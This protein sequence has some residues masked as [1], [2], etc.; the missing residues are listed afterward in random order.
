MSDYSW[1]ASVNA[2]VMRLARHQSDRPRRR[3]HFRRRRLSLDELESRL[4]PVVSTNFSAGTLLLIVPATDGPNVSLNV[5]SV[6]SITSNA[7]TP[8]NTV[9]MTLVGDTFAAGTGTTVPFGGNPYFT[10]GTA[11]APN[12][13]LTFTTSPS[14]L[15]NSITPAVTLTELDL[16]LQCAGDTLSLNL[17]AG[18]AQSAEVKT[19]NINPTSGDSITLNAITISGALS[20][21][22]SS[23][24]VSP[25]SSSTGVTIGGSIN[26][27]GGVSIGGTSGPTGPI[28]ISPGSSITTTNKDISMFAKTLIVSN[29]ATLTPNGGSVSLSEGA[30]VSISIK[31]AQTAVTGLGVTGGAIS[32]SNSLS[33]GSF[34]L[35]GGNVTVSNALNATSGNISITGT[36]SSTSDGVDLLNANAKLTATGTGSITI[37]GTANGTGKGVVLSAATLSTTAGNIAIT[38]S[39]SVGVAMIGGSIGS[40]GGGVTIS[41]TG[42]GTGLSGGAYGVDI[43]PGSGARVSDASTGPVKITGT[44]GA[45]STT[46]TN[47]NAGVR[48]NGSTTSVTV[49]NGTLNISGTGGGTGSDNFGVDIEG[50]AHIMVATPTSPSTLADG[51]AISIT[52]PA[53]GGAGAT[54][55]PTGDS[56]DGVYISGS[57]TM[58][59]AQIGGVNISGTGTGTG[60]NE[61]GVDIDSGASATTTFNGPIKI[62]GTG[63]VVGSTGNTGVLVRGTVNT[64]GGA[65]GI[66]GTGGGTQK[67]NVGI[68]LETGS[69]VE[70]EIGAITLTGTG[71]NGSPDNSKGDDSDDSADGNVGVQIIGS[72]VTTGAGGI[73]I[74]GTGNGSGQSEIGVLIESGSQTVPGEEEPVTETVASVVTTNGNGSIAIKG[75]GSALGTDN[76]C[77]VDITSAQTEV[78]TENGALAIT[79]TGGGST[80]DNFGVII[81]SG[82]LVTNSNNGKGPIT[83]AGTGGDGLE[84]VGGETTPT[85]ADDNV[86]VDIYGGQVSAG[87]GGVTITGTGNGTGDDERG[88]VIRT[89][90][91]AGSAGVS[92]NQNGAVTIKGT[93]S[94][95]GGED[96]DGVFIQGVG[97]QLATGSGALS[98]SGIGGGAEYGNYG[99]NLQGMIGTGYF[100]PSVPAGAINLSGTGG[101]GNNDTDAGD[102]DLGKAEN[103]GVYIISGGQITGGAGGVVISGTA[104]GQGNEEYG[105]DLEGTSSVAVGQNGNLKITGTAS[106]I[107]FDY[108][109]GVYVNVTGTGPA[110]TTGSGALTITGTGG[111]TDSWNYGIDLNSG[112]I[113]SQQGGAVSLSGTAGNGGLFLTAGIS[114]GQCNEGVFISG[115]QVLAGGGGLTITGTGNGQGTLARGVD[116][117]GGAVIAATHN[118]DGP[119]TIKGTGGSIALGQNSGIY[120][121]GNGTQLTTGRGALSV[122]GA[123]GGT[124]VQNDGVDV[125]G[126]AVI[127]STGGGLVSVSGTC[128]PGTSNDVGV[129]VSGSSAVAP[130]AVTTTTGN[131]TITGT[132]GNGTGNGNVGVVI[133]AGGQVSTQRGTIT[134][135]GTGNGLGNNEDGVD[136]IGG[137]AVTAA[138]DGT[139]TIK[140]NGGPGSAS[141]VGV[142][143]SDLSGVS[144][145]KTTVSTAYGPLSITGT[146]GNGIGNG[147]DGVFMNSATIQ[148]NVSTLT[149]GVSI[150]GIGSGLGSFSDGVDIVGGVHLSATADGTIKISGTGSNGAPDQNDNV[151]VYISELSPIITGSQVPSGT[152]VSL[153]ASGGPQVTTV[154]GV[155]SLNGTGGDFP[156]TTGTVANGGSNNY[157]VAIEAN[158]LITANTVAPAPVGNFTIVGTGGGGL[159]TGNNNIGVYLI[160]GGVQLKGGPASTISGTQGLGSGANNQKVSAAGIQLTP[161]GLVAVAPLPT[162]VVQIT[163]PANNSSIPFSNG[164]VSVVATLTA[165]ITNGIGVATLDGTAPTFHYYQLMNGTVQKDLG[166]SAPTSFG[167]YQ[168]TPSF[169]GSL[170]YQPSTGSPIDFSIAQVAPTIVFTTLGSSPF[171]KNAGGTYTASAIYNGPNIGTTSPLPV[172]ALV[173]G[174]NSSPAASLETVTLVTAANPLVYYAGTFAS[175]PIP[176]GTVALPSAPAAVGNYTVVAKFLGSTDYASVSV[177]ANFSITQATPTIHITLPS[178]IA[179]SAQSPDV[180]FPAD[181]FITGAGSDS[182]NTSKSLEGLSLTL[183]YSL[184]NPDGSFTDLNSNSLGAHSTVAGTYA[185]TAHFAATKD[186]SAPPALTFVFNVVAGP[187]TAFVVKYPNGTTPVTAGTLFGLNVTP[188]DQFGNPTTLSQSVSVTSSDPQASQ[189]GTSLAITNGSVSGLSLKTANNLPGQAATTVTVTDPLDEVVSALKLSI[190]GTGYGSGTTV[191]FSGGGGSGAAATAVIANGVITALTITNPGS[192]YTT[193]PTVSFANTGGGTGAAAT[194]TVTAITGSTTVP[195]QAAAATQFVLSA[196]GGTTFNPPRSAPIAANSLTTQDGPL[197]MILE[198]VDPFGNVSTSYAKSVNVTDQGTSVGEVFSSGTLNLNTA[199]NIN[200]KTLGAQTITVSEVVSGGLPSFAIPLTVTVGTLA[201]FGVVVTP[202]SAAAGSAFTIKVT[203]EDAAGIALSTFPTGS[204]TLTDNVNGNPISLPAPATGSVSISS[205]VA[206]ISVAAT[207]APTTTAPAFTIAGSSTLKVSVGTGASTV[208]GLSSPFTIT[209]LPTVAQL[210]VTLTPPAT[211]VTVNVPFGLT[212][213]ELDVF[214]NLVTGVNPNNIS[215]NLKLTSTPAGGSTA[216]SLNFTPPA[217]NA[218]AGGVAAITGV[219]LTTPGI[220]QT[221]TAVLTNSGTSV[222]GSLTLADPPGD[223]DLFSVVGLVLNTAS[224]DL[225]TVNSGAIG[226]TSVITVV[227]TTLAKFVVRNAPATA[228]VGRRFDITVVAEDSYGNILS[229]YDPSATLTVSCKNSMRRPLKGTFNHGVLTFAGV[230]LKKTGVQTLTIASGGHTVTTVRLMVHAKARANGGTQQRPPR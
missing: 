15:T 109:V 212:I 64:Q 230:T 76:N 198:A 193:P 178:N 130:S 54:P 79:G 136:I 150:T 62:Q 115:T 200:L 92:A 157:G 25:S 56:N 44:G 26:A 20:V 4:A 229:T 9:T 89:G 112:T 154:S 61:L 6:T 211:T 43:E 131:L 41:G 110:L 53:P 107:G 188:E 40:N 14:T 73:T 213:K 123:G 70:S 90:E 194:A 145:T 164:P 75:T 209:A 144:T 99:I 33:A 224:N 223:P 21:L 39:G 55:T 52:A 125:V 132:G 28:T 146:G 226:G 151:G 98:I 36:G 5:M 134:I 37:K 51:G 114:N 183:D 142:L 120:M 187:A 57:N 77:G 65:L 199:A 68:D 161:A 152:T 203:S 102:A 219:T 81:Q 174:V 140:G 175:L 222:R 225:R 163:S 69:E 111:G 119:L 116:I 180:N 48:I 207:A 189:L 171:V 105:V 217:S 156:G 201:Q 172:T 181:F 7:N 100:D 218:F 173:S 141:N 117:E 45:A 155:L 11:S 165:P 191:V 47:N 27:P 170:N 101:N 160:G 166:A 202:T 19:V 227:P 38:G 162:P 17:S 210:G 113:E 22:N 13:Q 228:V 137:A 108:A 121:S 158:A 63:S 93:G 204:I 72:T 66:T 32:I 8:T 220:T 83:I 221:L 185:V 60:M 127:Q 169:P 122:T 29:T 18:A 168:V 167:N 59:T 148:V 23:A 34:S 179:A 12:T 206:T 84:M 1:L 135:T 215:S 71:G 133:S 74:T 143:L 30:N 85:G 205:G 128:S 103:S 124:T 35:T 82:A 118:G 138:L 208:T 97:E 24:T 49:V 177:L 186:Y 184:K 192:A 216:T 214:G 46:P 67:N 50:G 42:T 147:N 3:A 94:P 104:I 10:L 139:V 197:N 2:R 88:V 176:T 95:L 80:Y 159:G 153:P 87:S 196:L 126:G 86:G 129:L 31:S 182:S 195:V 78:E 16:D 58:V 106:P 190:G 96:N 91:K 149:G